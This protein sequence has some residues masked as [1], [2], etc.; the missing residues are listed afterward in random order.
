MTGVC[1][2]RLF[3]HNDY[4]IRIQLIYMDLGRARPNNGKLMTLY[5]FGRNFEAAAAVYDVA[6]YSSYMISE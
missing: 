3:M 6:R 1:A 2:L 4:H 5:N